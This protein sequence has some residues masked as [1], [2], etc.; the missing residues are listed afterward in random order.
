MI[1]LFY[2]KIYL[3]LYGEMKHNSLL[4]LLLLLNNLKFETKMKS[5]FLSFCFIF[6]SSISI[7]PL[8]FP[9]IILS[10]QPFSLSSFPK[11]FAIHCCLTA[12]ASVFR[13]DPINSIYFESKILHRV[14]E[15]PAPSV[16][17]F[18]G[19]GKGCFLFTSSHYRVFQ[20]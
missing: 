10:L 7:S 17:S 14:Q 9:F 4:V 16:I 2:S 5:I 11:D 12:H 20:L 13:V 6:S 8:S 15:L 18:C 1:H 19:G 3:C